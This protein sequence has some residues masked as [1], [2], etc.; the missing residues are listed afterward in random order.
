MRYWHLR[1]LAVVLAEQPKSPRRQGRH[2][3]HT[4]VTRSSN[5]LEEDDK[6]AAD[7]RKN[8]ATIS[9][10]AAGMAGEKLAPNASWQQ[11]G[12]NE[13]GEQRRAPAM[14]AATMAVRLIRRGERSLLA[15]R[16]SG[17]GDSTQAR[18]KDGW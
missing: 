13:L 8:P 14:S 5:R 18:N 15:R 1:D 11:P 6:D 7:G 12:D 9:I 4:G 16:R 10:R 3:A 2:F 17:E